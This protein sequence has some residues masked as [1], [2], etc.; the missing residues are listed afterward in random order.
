M[1]ACVPETPLDGPPYEGLALGG[2]LREM[3][4]RLVYLD[5]RREKLDQR[6]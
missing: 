6:W 2:E 4:R 5:Q 3:K 1:L